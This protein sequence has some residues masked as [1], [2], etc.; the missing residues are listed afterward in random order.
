MSAG[1]KRGFLEKQPSSAI[2]VAAG[3]WKKRY[4][5][6]KPKGGQARTAR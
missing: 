4:I 2:K 1:T 5:A 3:G 6:I